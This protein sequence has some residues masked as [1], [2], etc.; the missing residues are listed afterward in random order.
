MQKLPDS[1]QVWNFLFDRSPLFHWPWNEKE[2]FR[3]KIPENFGIPHKLKIGHQFEALAQA[4][5]LPGISYHS[6][7]QVNGEGRTLG[8]LDLLAQINRRWNH[9]EMCCKFYLHHQGKWFGPNAKDRLDLKWEKL[10][11]KQLKLGS[12]PEARKMLSTLGINEPLKTQIFSRGFLYREAGSTVTAPV[13]I[14]DNHPIGIWYRAKNFP[15]REMTE[16]YVWKKE[17]WLQPHP[18][19]RLALKPSDELSRATRLYYRRKGKNFFEEAFI[20]P[21]AWPE[22]T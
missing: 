6:N 1:Q 16:V 14:S 8:E 9:V 21:D 2:L 15:W 20:V 22:I 11:E 19:D 5:L 18:F 3:N 10:T 13:F 12:M 4:A 17:E 7:L